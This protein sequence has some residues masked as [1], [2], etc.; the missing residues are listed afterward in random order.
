MTVINGNNRTGKMEIK[1]GIDYRKHVRLPFRWVHARRG[2]KYVKQLNYIVSYIKLARLRLITK[3]N[4]KTQR[5]VLKVGN[6]N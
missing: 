4:L 5:P 3:V 6:R 2:G 1:R